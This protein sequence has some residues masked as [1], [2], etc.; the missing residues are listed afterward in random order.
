MATSAS[1]RLRRFFGLF[2]R[3]DRLLVLINADPDAMASAMALKRLLWRQVSAAT[4]AHVNTITR[5]DN[6]AMIRLLKLDLVPKKE[7][8]QG[9]FTRYAILDSQ[10]SHHE[11][12]QGINFDVIIDHH[13]DT[14]AKAPFADVRPNYGAT[15][16]IMTQYLR[17]AKIKPSAKL[18]TALFYGI[19]TDTM[20]FRRKTVIE[21]V[22]AFQFLFRHVNVHVAQSIEQA[23]M[24]LDFLQYYRIALE[25]VRVRKRRMH[26][27]IGP[28][29]NP[30]VCVSI[31]DFFMKIHDIAWAIVSGTYQGRL[32][33]IVRNDGIRKDAGKFLSKVFGELGPAGGHKAMARAEIPLKNLEGVVQYRDDKAL[34]RWITKRLDKKAQSSK[35]KA[36]RKG[37]KRIDRLNYRL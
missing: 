32:I 7:V 16:T 2:S 17:A 18:A 22:N 31:A 36:E 34:S 33:I 23:E 10:P 27:H 1:E 12:F 26:V 14:G 5:P 28:V 15:S 35:L 20:N 19:K 30:D 6:L 4:I 37:N 24:T 29:V 21:D 3:E 13:P 9:Q 11:D 8:D 25:G